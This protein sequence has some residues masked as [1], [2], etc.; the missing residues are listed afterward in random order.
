MYLEL[1]SFSQMK[2]KVPDVDVER[3]LGVEDCE[4]QFLPIVRSGACTDVGFRSSMEDVYVCV[5]NFMQEYGLENS[6]DG[7]NAFY[8]VLSPF[9]LTSFFFFFLMNFDKYGVRTHMSIA[10]YN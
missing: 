5:D 3:G 9:F 2:T 7:P 6:L 4:S 10:R 8:G 1:E